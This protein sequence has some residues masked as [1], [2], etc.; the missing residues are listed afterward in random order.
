MTWLVAQRLFH[1]AIVILGVTT[2]VF[3]ALRMT[4]DPALM[5]LPGDPRPKI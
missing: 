1:F 3:I 5:L 2:L 4:G